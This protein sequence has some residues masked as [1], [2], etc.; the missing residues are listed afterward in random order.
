MRF[1]CLQRRFQTRENWNRLVH[2]YVGIVYAW[3]LLPGGDVVRK[4]IGNSS[5]QPNTITDNTMNIYR[6]LASAFVALAPEGFHATHETFVEHV[7]LRLY[8]DNINGVISLIVSS[9]YNP[10]TISIYLQ[11]GGVSIKFNVC[12]RVEDLDWLSSSFVY[13]AGHYLPLRN[14]HKALASLLQMQPRGETIL[15]TFERAIGLY[16]A[17]WVS[18]EFR[19][20]MKPLLQL[21]SEI[22]RDME[23]S[24]RLRN[25][26][27]S[28]EELF[29]L[30]THT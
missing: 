24:E 15:R 16:Y 29:S 6:L 9:W 11:S 22:T 4:A 21:L 28:D 5:G 13:I 12:L 20:F 8:G 17:Y 18:T 19:S 14:Y 2:Y 10:D 3:S 7:L 23:G 30:Y 26:L 25:C 27:L 1:N